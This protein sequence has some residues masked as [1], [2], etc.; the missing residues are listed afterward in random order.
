VIFKDGWHAAEV[1]P[2]SRDIEWQWTKGAATIAFKNPKR[3]STLYLQLDNPDAQ[4]RGAHQVDIRI[5]DQV[6]TTLPVSATDVPV[7]KIPLPASALGEGDMVE[8]Q[9]VPDASFVPA[10]EAGSTNADPRELGVR[11]FHV[12]VLP[13]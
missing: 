1:A 3:D 9:L 10:N 4:K 8:V 13:S 12:Y 2:Q 5:G 7:H 11:V 6:L